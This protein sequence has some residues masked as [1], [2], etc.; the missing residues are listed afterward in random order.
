MPA[1]V[2]LRNVTK[3]YVRGKQRVEVLH[4]VDLD[5]E[6]GEFLA[7]M[8]PSGSGK[9]TLLNVISGIT[10]ADAGKVLVDGTDVTKLN[11][12]R[13]RPIPC[14]ADRDRVSDVQPAPGVQRV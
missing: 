9:T 10:E 1:I 7:L 4:G 13:A 6:A 5:I 12:V 3:S 11:E 8:G 14:G 2:S